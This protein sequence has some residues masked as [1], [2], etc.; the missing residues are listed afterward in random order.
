MLCPEDALI[1]LAE[2]I[3][4]QAVV[5]FRGLREMGAL[6]G[7]GEFFPLVSQESLGR[8]YLP[9]ELQITA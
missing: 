7:E 1:Y 9:E 3:I 2:A 4:V 5:D 8:V 6:P